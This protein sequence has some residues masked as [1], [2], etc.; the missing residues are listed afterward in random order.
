MPIWAIIPPNGPLVSNSY[1]NRTK[2]GGGAPL[3]RFRSSLLHDSWQPLVSLSAAKEQRQQTQ[4]V[5]DSHDE[6][7]KD[8]RNHRHKLDQDVE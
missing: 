2:G 5:V 8:Y 4:T 6:S 3:A 1:P 7:G